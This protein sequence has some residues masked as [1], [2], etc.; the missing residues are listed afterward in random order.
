M[1]PL[2]VEAEKSLGFYEN[3][4]QISCGQLRDH[5]FT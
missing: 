1:Q 2:S 3:I 5:C 4:L